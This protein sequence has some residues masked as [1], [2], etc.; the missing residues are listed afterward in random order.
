[1]RLTEIGL[2]ANVSPGSIHLRAGSREAAG[3][4]NSAKEAPVRT[5]TI[6]SA[7]GCVSAASRN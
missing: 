5:L 6:V 4:L 3:L 1:M 7:G 2:T